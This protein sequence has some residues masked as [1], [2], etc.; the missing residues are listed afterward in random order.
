MN[1]PPPQNLH[2]HIDPGTVLTPPPPGTA[3]IRN[4]SNMD[5]LPVGRVDGG[6]SRCTP[7]G[8]WRQSGWRRYR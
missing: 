7:P 5:P 6:W 2:S 3:K 1:L 4:I 8:T